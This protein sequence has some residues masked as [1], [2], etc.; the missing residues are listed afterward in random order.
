MPR[1][2]HFVRC[3]HCGLEFTCGDC[4]TFTCPKCRANGHRGLWLECEVCQRERKVQDEALLRARIAELE[5]F[6]RDCR[7]NWDCD[8]ASHK[9]RGG[10]D[11]RACN[12]ERLLGP[13]VA[14]NPNE[15]H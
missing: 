1:S 13:R 11:C 15:T 9:Y 12:A 2:T 6:V 4:I 14:P 7:D 5:A 8:E 3:A 10:H